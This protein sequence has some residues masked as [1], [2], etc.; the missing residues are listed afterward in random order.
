MFE[1]SM[2]RPVLD[3]QQQIST[4]DFRWSLCR[5]SVSPDLL[6]FVEHVR[7][8]DQSSRT[9]RARTSCVL[10]ASEPK[11]DHHK[12]RQIRTPELSDGSPSPEQ[13]GVWTPA[14]GLLQSSGFEKKLTVR[15]GPPPKGVFVI[16]CRIG[17]CVA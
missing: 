8:F 1:I 17:G 13:V 9:Q 15:C 12:S 11:R 6:D 2:T 5:W 14:S 4:T 3:H 10:S 16:G 7:S